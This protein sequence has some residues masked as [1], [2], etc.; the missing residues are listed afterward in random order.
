MR[1]YANENF[2]QPVVEA[3]RTLGHDVL[4][5]LE[6]GRANQRIE[7]SEVLRFANDDDR[8]LLTLNR[9]HFRRLHQAGQPHRGIVACTR[10]VDFARQARRI[11]VAIRTGS[12]VVGQFIVVTRPE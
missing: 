10:D 12:T 9:R 5:S 3:L 7:D 6:A 4:T 11:V 1:F 2:P 8:V